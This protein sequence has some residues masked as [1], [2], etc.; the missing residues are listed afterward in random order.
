ME[1]YAKLMKINEP[2][3]NVEFL[4]IFLVYM[5]WILNIV[6]SVKDSPQAILIRG[7]EGI[8]GPGRVGKILEIDKSFNQ[9][10]IEQSQRIWIEDAPFVISYTLH[11]RIGIEY[12]SPEWQEKLWRYVLD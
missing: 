1:K 2:S 4:S 3:E 6:T 5:Y 10:D 7:L 12:S 8:N 11:K 9:E